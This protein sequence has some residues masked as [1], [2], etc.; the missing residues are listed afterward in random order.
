MY[1]A[2][3]ERHTGRGWYKGSY[4]PI[5]NKEPGLFFICGTKAYKYLPV[6]SGCS[7]GHAVPGGLT[8]HPHI[9]APGITNL[10]SFLHR[11]KRKFTIN[12]LVRR[13]TGFHRFTRVFLPWLG[14]AELEQAI[15]NVSGQLEIAL[16]T[17]QMP[18]AYSTN[19]SNQWPALPYRID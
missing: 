12:P 19:R 13:P 18:W 1:H 5:L 17:L 11:S 10:G 3:K 8:V 6:A 14:V 9:T 16:T 15:V 7:L 2:P 4:S